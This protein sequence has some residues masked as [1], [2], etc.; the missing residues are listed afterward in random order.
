MSTTSTKQT[1]THHDSSYVVVFGGAG[2]GKTSMLNALTGEEH[3]TSNTAIGCTFETTLYKPTLRNG[4]QYKFID[5]LALEEASGGTM[6]NE[7]ARSVL[8]Q[9]LVNLKNGLNLLI[10]VRRSGRILVAEKNNYMFVDAITQHKVPTICVM[11]GCEAQSN[12]SKCAKDEEEVFANQ[13]MKFAKIVPVCFA[14]GGRLE[15]HYRELRTTSTEEVWKAIEVHAST[16]PVKFINVTT[17]GVLGALKRKWNRFY[18]LMNM[19]SLKANAHRDICYML[20]LMGVKDEQERKRIAEEV[21][22][23]N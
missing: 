17:P 7:R 14:K 6:S 15:E 5:T 12:M 13:G 1:A 20:E 21:E 22:K 19:P 16:T 4:I 23:A 8:V 11:T 18:D 2:A 10:F 9:L 3:L